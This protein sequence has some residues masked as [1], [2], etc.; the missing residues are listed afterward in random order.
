MEG[1]KKGKVLPYS[2]PS[3][4][5]RADPGVQAV[6]PQVTWSHPP[7]GRLPLVSARPAVTFPA[8]ERHRPS[9]GPNYTAWWQR[10]MRVSSLPKAV[11]WKQTGRDSNP[12]PFGSWVN[13]LPLSHTGHSGGCNKTYIQV[14]KENL[15]WV[16]GKIL[17]D[18]TTVCCGT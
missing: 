4:G 13:A 7:G 10:H 1:V 3:V 9:A 12:R 8:E 16:S 18:T 2:L 14:G 6:S 17:S 11:T 5:P 15:E